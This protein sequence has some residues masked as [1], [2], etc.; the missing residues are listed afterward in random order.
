L[1]ISLPEWGEV[2]WSGG[3]GVLASWMS[4]WVACWNW[5]LLSKCCLWL[6]ESRLGGLH[7]GWCWIVWNIIDWVSLLLPW[8]GSVG[9][10]SVFWISIASWDWWLF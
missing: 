5:L 3:W 8:R 4:V 7:N 6:G 1:D 9:L 10:A 2:L